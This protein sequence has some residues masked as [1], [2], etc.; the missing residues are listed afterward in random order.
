MKEVKFENANRITDRSRRVTDISRGC[1]AVD[2]D[3]LKYFF[4]SINEAAE[5]VKKY[6]FCKTNQHISSVAGTIHTACR[7]LPKRGRLAYGFEWFFFEDK[8]C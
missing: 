6:N 1:Y 4:D 2:A 5:N 8:N 3:G 7:N